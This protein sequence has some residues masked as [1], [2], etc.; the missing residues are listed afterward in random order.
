MTFIKYSLRLFMGVMRAPTPPLK[1]PWLFIVALV[2]RK[3]MTEPAPAKEFSSVASFHC[4]MFRKN[5]NMIPLLSSQRLIFTAHC[6]H[7]SL[8]SIHQR[9][10]TADKFEFYA[11]N[12][13]VSTTK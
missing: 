2:Q 9:T 11:R 4:R 1:P 5:I 6:F 10:F 3:K 7:R 12:K 8:N 13:T